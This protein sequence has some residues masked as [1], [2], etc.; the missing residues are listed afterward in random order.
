MLDTAAVGIAR[1]TALGSKLMP[2]T[3]LSKTST[4]ETMATALPMAKRF[5]KLLEFELMIGTPQHPMRTMMLATQM[6]GVRA[7][8]TIKTATTTTAITNRAG[9]ILVVMLLTQV[10][11]TTTTT[12]TLVTRMAPLPPTSSRL[13][14]MA[15]IAGI[16]PTITEKAPGTTRPP[17]TVVSGRRGHNLDPHPLVTPAMFSRCQGHGTWERK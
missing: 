9:I 3:R 1:M 14:P 15:S 11:T 12:T 8:A 10:G 16:I 6:I 4:V 2:K 13:L 7:G 5:G 17:T